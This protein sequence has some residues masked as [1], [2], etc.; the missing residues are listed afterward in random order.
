MS[1]RLS[2]ISMRRYCRRQAR[3]E[4]CGQGSNGGP[5]G[6]GSRHRGHSAGLSGG[7]GGGGCGGGI[8]AGMT[9]G[10]RRRTNTR[11]RSSLRRRRRSP[12]EEGSWHDGDSRAMTGSLPSQVRM[13]YNLTIGFRGGVLWLTT[14]FLQASG[15]FQWSVVNSHMVSIDPDSG[16]V[17]LPPLRGRFCCQ[18]DSNPSL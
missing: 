17:S 5:G 9:G 1:T 8:G 4:R 7:G 2:V 11:R 15:A 10:S 3:H 18:R 6:C 12:P 16:S 13:L 14:D